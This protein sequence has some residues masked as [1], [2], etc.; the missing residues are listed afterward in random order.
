MSKCCGV[1]IC[2]KAGGRRRGLCSNSDEEQLTR[3]TS[4]F[5]GEKK[6]PNRGSTIP[7]KA[8]VVGKGGKRER[9]VERRTHGVFVLRV[10]QTSFFSMFVLDAVQWL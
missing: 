1:Y 8:C 7:E 5:I 6:Y 2:D 9:A 4:D 10:Q 3:F